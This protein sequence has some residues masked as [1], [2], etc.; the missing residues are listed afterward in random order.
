[1]PLNTSRRSCSR[2]GA[3][4][5]I[6]VRYGAT[7]SHSSSITSLGYGF[8]AIQAVPLD[9]RESSEHA[10]EVAFDARCD[11]SH[12]QR[13]YFGLKSIKIDGNY[14]MDVTV[15]LKRKIPVYSLVDLIKGKIPTEALDKHIILIG[16]E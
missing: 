16:C 8:L 12:N 6:S 4:S 2:C 9:H 10:L 13:A 15:P 7:K 5:V 14:E 3:S 11:L 1:M